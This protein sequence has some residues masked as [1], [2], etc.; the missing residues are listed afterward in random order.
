ML[1]DGRVV[2][3]GP[4]VAQCLTSLI[5]DNEV[6]K[7]LRAHQEGGLLIHRVVVVR[8]GCLRI[9]LWCF[10]CCQI[11]RRLLGIDAQGMVEARHQLH[12]AVCIGNR[13]ESLVA[14]FKVGMVMTLTTCTCFWIHTSITKTCFQRNVRC[15]T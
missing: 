2:L 4:F 14:Y 9:G 1:G 13:H 10:Q 11:R 5:V 15:T 7:D 8:G 6:F 3:S 12:V